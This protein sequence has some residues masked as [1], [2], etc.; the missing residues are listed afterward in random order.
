[1]KEEELLSKVKELWG[2]ATSVATMAEAQW[3][4]NKK[5]IHSKHLT[6]RKVGQSSVFVP[7][8]EKFHY[9]KQADHFFAF[10]GDNPVSLKQTL[11]SSKEG[12]TIM[13]RVVNFYIKEAGGI[14][15]D[16][17]VLNCAHNALT[18][19]FAP[20]FVDWDRDIE[21]FDTEVEALDENGNIAIKQ[22]K[23]ERE[24]YSYPTLEVLSPDDARIDPSVGWN[25]VGLARFGIIR[26]WRDKAFAE[27]M[28]RNGDWPEIED[29][30]FNN[31]KD[32]NSI[33]K[34]TASEVIA[35]A[36]NAT[37]GFIEVWY[38][39]FFNDEGIPVRAVTIEGME[40]LEGEKE[41]EFDTSDKDGSDPWPFGVGCIYAE[42]HQLYSRA[43]PEKLQELQIE[44]NAR[45]NQRA[46]NIALSL[47]PEKFMSR[48]AGID[49]AV[50]SRSM[51]GKVNVV[52]NKESVW[53]DRPPDVTASSYQE[54]NVI[55]S[56][57]EQLVSESAQ[58]AGGSSQRKE[59]ATVAKIQAA[60]TNTS[61]SLDTNVFGITFPN[62]AVQKIIRMI[63]Q[64]ASPELFFAAAEDSMVS[65]ADPYTE[66]L[67]G[68]FNISVGNGV[69]QTVRDIAISQASNTAAIIQSVYGQNANFFPIISPML[70]ALGLNPSD[71]IQDPT[72]DQ[73]NRQIGQDAGGVGGQNQ[74]PVQQNAAVQGGALASNTNTQNK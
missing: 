74:I 33:L 40:V 1:M 15:W 27:K 32:L 13:E 41:L 23:E 73:Q 47:N 69:Q 55:T 12:A 38:S 67:T 61:V 48:N 60:N 56:D 37:D 36:N 62:R 44:R 70:E 34:Q 42:P 43:M 18:Y 45:R 57:A 58:R 68:T 26:R 16:T 66:A 30:F 59:T 64:A 22:Q 5:L 28:Q 72:A 52:A 6:A 9:R 10:T 17:S 20:W 53:W 49:P 51:S 11:T 25:E 29:R 4:K 35:I 3:V 24:I 63:R 39:Y 50:L 19:N 46:D 8:I 2:S 54:E 21:E 65:V 71:I 14:D 31:K 7:M